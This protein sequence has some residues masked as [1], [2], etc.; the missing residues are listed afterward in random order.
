MME[1][2]RMRVSL[3][4]TEIEVPG[5]TT[6]GEV[7]EGIG[8]LID[9]ARLV[10]ELVV[11][12]RF[13]DSTDGAALAAWR[14]EGGERIRVGTETPLDF[15]RKRRAE[16][17]GHLRTIGEMLVAA[18]GGFTSGETTAANHVL[19]EAA[20]DLQLALE[21]DRNLALLDGAARN[22]EAI[23]ATVERIGARLNDAERDRR[24][25][26]VAQLLSDELIPAIR[27]SAPPS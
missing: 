2:S 1:E 24:W 25:G 6:L 12:G 19:A 9:P 8:P 4:G 17:A 14:L 10:T 3:D 11:D 15:A 26:E 7:L 22:C 21:L 16:L 5:A 13:A 20:R 27:A 18:A 23:A